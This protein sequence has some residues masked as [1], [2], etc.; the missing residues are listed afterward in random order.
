MWIDTPAP[1]EGTLEEIEQNRASHTWLTSD[2]D[3]R[4]V[5]CDS[6]PWHIHADYPCG[7]EAPRVIKE[8]SPFSA[9]RVVD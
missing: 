5:R 1:F 6:K 9:F 8:L 3:A 7:V 4:C 2:E